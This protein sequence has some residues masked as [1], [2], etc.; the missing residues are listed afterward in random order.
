LGQ[1]SQ[2][3]VYFQQALVIQKGVSDRAG[4]GSILSNIGVLL[5]RTGEFAKATE[6]LFDAVEALESLRPGLAD[7]E[8][9][10][11]VETQN[12][13][14]QNLQQSLIAQDRMNEAL[15]ASERGR[16]RAFIEQLAQRLGSQ[17]AEELVKL[18]LPS[19]DNLKAIAT[20]QKVTLVEYSLVPDRQLQTSDTHLYI[21]IIKPTGEVHFH[22]TD[23]STLA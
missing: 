20:T 6:T 13:T 10:Q 15:V 4:E 5:L 11:L 2:A 18:N 23:L 21:W 8:K 17:S 3:L 16:N 12:S 9:I 19:L 1:Y 7:S 14:Y 22:Q